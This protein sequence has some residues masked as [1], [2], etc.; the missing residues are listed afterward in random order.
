MVL[1]Y[2]DRIDGWWNVKVK[3][4]RTITRKASLGRQAKSNTKSNTKGK[5]LWGRDKPVSWLQR[6]RVAKTSFL[7]T[8]G[9]AK[10]L[11]KSDFLIDGLPWGRPCRGFWFVV[12]QAL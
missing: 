12:L 8:K 6:S 10:C 11:D 9:C 2:G 1:R 3:F 4:H 5:T 7:R